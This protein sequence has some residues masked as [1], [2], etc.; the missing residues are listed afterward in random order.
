MPKNSTEL[1]FHWQQ[2]TVSEP[3]GRFTWL[4]SHRAIA[5]GV[6]MFGIILVV[7]V[8]GR[9]LTSQDQVAVAAPQNNGLLSARA[10][11]FT[12]QGKILG[13]SGAAWIIGGVPVMVSDQ[14]QLA[15]GV[16]PGDAVSVLGQI[17][18]DGKW[19]AKRI[20]LI[21]DQ[22]SFFSFG[23]PVERRTGTAWQVAGISVHVDD[24]TQIATPI[25]DNELVVVTF[26]VMPDGTWLALSIETLSAVAGNPTPTILL[27]TSTPPAPD[28][29][30]SPP[31]PAT[32]QNQIGS[33]QK[34]P[35]VKPEKKSDNGSSGCYKS[36]GKGKGS[37]HGRCSGP[38]GGNG[39][40][41]DNQ[42]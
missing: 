19:L 10:Y 6:A 28:P 34:S 2:E 36:N 37:K 41:G 20:A 13:G 31:E 7:F 32:G 22:D 26:K 3:A 35:A 38:D 8:G 18:K 12:G 25:Q 27:P 11:Q 15:N 21:T 33:D 5:L 9:F 42:D 1:P 29:T 23:G 4:R 40:G 17:G 30:A 16:H 39:G 14:T 24:Q